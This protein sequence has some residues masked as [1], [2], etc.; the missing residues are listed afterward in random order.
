MRSSQHFSLDAFAPKCLQ[1]TRRDK[2]HAPASLPD[3]RGVP[4]RS[5][6]GS[7]HWQ[8]Q[9]LYGA[10]IREGSCCRKETIQPEVVER[11]CCTK[12]WAN[13]RIFSEAVTFL[14]THVGRNATPIKASSWAALPPHTKS[15]G[16]EKHYPLGL[17]LYTSL[18]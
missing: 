17:Y 14:Q 7:T 1:S 3:P 10:G 15:G 6:R 11:I 12:V 2:S 9:R 18:T 4:A 8:F 5:C 13:R 16:S